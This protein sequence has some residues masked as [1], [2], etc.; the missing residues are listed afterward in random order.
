MSTY[1]TLLADLKKAMLA[2]DEKTTRVLRS[3]KA[4]LLEKEVSI[5][6]GGEATLTEEQVM[7]VFIKATKQRKDSLEQFEN[8]GR[9][10]LAS[11]ER[12]ELVIIDGYLPKK[13]T[14]DELE[15]EIVAAIAALGAAAPSDMG[16]VMGYLTPRLKGRADGS[17]I[18]RIVKSKLQQ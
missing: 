2:R 17:E 13:L 10:D 18:S 3:L 14:P 9:E 1:D 5:R 4:A 6:T 11:I 16:K 8:A 7:D 15:A 12:E